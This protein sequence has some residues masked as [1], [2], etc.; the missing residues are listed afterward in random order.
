ME[1]VTQCVVVVPPPE[2]GEQV[3][4]TSADAAVCVRLPSRPAATLLQL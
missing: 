2:I 1:E 4:D 3:P